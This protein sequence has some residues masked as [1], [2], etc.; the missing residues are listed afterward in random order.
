[1]C[2]C[3]RVFLSA[4]S[5][6]ADREGDQPIR[7]R[8]GENQTDAESRGEDL[9]MSMHSP[10]LVCCIQLVKYTAGCVSAA[11]NEYQL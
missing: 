2:A 1:M 11:C 6:Q 3:V 4:G 7:G 8:V 5:E 9:T 10:H